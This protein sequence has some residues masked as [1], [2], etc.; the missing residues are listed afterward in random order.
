ME[1]SWVLLGLSWALLRS[2]WAHLGPSWAH[3]GPILGPLGLLG[4]LLGPFWRMLQYLVTVGPFLAI[5]P[6]TLGYLEALF[7]RLPTHELLVDYVMMQT[8]LVDSVI[9]CPQRGPAG[10]AKR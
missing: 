3:L 5:S 6:A 10:C 1:L 7:R 9:V 2:S 8:L 4:G